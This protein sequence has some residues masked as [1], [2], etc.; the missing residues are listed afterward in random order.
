M[1]CTANVVAIPTHFH[2][3][4]QVEVGLR[5]AGQCTV[6]RE[7]SCAVRI[8]TGGTRDC[9][10]LRQRKICDALPHL[11]RHFRA[12]VSRFEEID[13]LRMTPKTDRRFIVDQIRFVCSLTRSVHRDLAV[14]AVVAGVR[15]RLAGIIKHDVRVEFLVA[16]VV[17]VAIGTECNRIIGDF[18]AKKCRIARRARTRSVA[19]Q[20][21][22]VTR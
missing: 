10:I 14:V 2:R 3:V 6:G 5:T 21:H 8:V 19:G 13:V 20:Q 12:M 15:P 11:G 7:P 4:G 16:A 1:T 17:D 18:S 9:L 22:I